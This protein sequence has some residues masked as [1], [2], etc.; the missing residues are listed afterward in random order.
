[1][2]DWKSALNSVLLCMRGEPEEQIYGELLRVAALNRLVIQ[3]DSD[4][5]LREWANQ[6]ANGFRV[7]IT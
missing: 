3:P 4:Q 6:A 5:Y 2:N 7:K 1:M